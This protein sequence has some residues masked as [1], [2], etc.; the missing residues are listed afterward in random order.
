MTSRVDIVIAGAGQVGS[1]HI[2]IAQQCTE[3]LRLIAVVEP[4]ENR[5]KLFERAWN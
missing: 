5:R 1:R 3:E 2:E 4:V